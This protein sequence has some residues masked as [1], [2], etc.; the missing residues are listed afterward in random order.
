MKYTRPFA[1]FATLANA[2]LQATPVNQLLH[3]RTLPD[4]STN[5]IPGANYDV[6]NSFVL[7]DLSQNDVLLTVPDIDSDR[8][9][10]FQVF[11]L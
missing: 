9:W 4:P 1:S 2:L 6:L 3:V 10:I 11:D 5:K 8:Y 7:L